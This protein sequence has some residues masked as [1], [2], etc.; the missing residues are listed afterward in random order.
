MQPSEA[1][2]LLPAVLRQQL[3][4][5]APQTHT[6]L[7][8]AHMFERT[9]ACKLHE[10]MEMH[11]CPYT[12]HLHAGQACIFS[13]T[14]PHLNPHSSNPS[15][16]VFPVNHATKNG[17]LSLPQGLEVALSVPARVAW[18]A[19]H[20]CTHSSNLILH[21]DTRELVSLVRHGCPTRCLTHK[22]LLL[23]CYRTTRHEPCV[24][25]LSAHAWPGSHSHI[26][27]AMQKHNPHL[28]LACAS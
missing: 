1:C 16:S 4:T 5:G 19:A 15:A 12:S 3:G 18:H 10:Q 20:S 27:A 17:I 8:A 25:M 2:Q 7:H 21:E 26:A 9:F 28:L 11:A 6:T 22:C 14:P 24:T 13:R 23:P